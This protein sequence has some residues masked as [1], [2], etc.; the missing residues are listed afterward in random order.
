MG[1][2][3]PQRQMQRQRGH[4]HFDGRLHDALAR[5]TGTGGRQRLEP[6]E[7]GLDERT[8][9]AHP[10]RDPLPLLEGEQGGRDE[11]VFGL[12]AGAGAAEAAA[13]VEGVSKFTRLSRIRVVAVDGAGEPATDGIEGL[14]GLH[15]RGGRLPGGCLLLAGGD[16]G[17]AH[18]GAGKL[19]Q[20]VDEVDPAGVAVIV[21]DE[22]I[23]RVVLLF[24]DLELP[25]D[26]PGAALHLD[27]FEP[28]GEAGCLE[29]R[30]GLREV[31]VE[32]LRQGAVGLGG[33]ADHHRDAPQ[34]PVRA[35]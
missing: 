11:L 20:G 32:K 24:G 23:R 15:E 9:A 34:K 28:E 29:L 12:V 17:G 3:I 14:E 16:R 7:R 19:Q 13:T 18:R 27:G 30:A 2:Q 21:D 33:G 25:G 31:V 8:H 22:Q 10:R 6:G 4:L 35:R 5:A 1:E 26:L